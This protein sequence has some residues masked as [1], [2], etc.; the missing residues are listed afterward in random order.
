MK[1]MKVS[2]LTRKYEGMKVMRAKE[3]A[4]EVAHWKMYSGVM[5]LCG[6]GVQTASANW[7]S[8]GQRT[9]TSGTRPSHFV[10]VEMDAEEH[11]ANVF[12]TG[13]F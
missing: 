7:T 12:I 10:A 4:K 1:H 5:T 13:V 8:N 11:K 6:S 9:G 3:V 2:Y